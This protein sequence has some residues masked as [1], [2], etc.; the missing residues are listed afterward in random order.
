MLVQPDQIL[1][2]EQNCSPQI[3]AD[4]HRGELFKLK[5][6]VG[7]R[8][9]QNELAMNVVKL[10]NKNEDPSFQSSQIWNSSTMAQQRKLHSRTPL[11]SLQKGLESTLS[12]NIRLEPMLQTH[13]EM[14]HL[15]DRLC[16]GLCLCIRSYFKVSDIRIYRNIFLSE[17]NSQD[18][19]LANKQ[20]V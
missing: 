4:E 12:A 19:Q 10:G 5:D 16:T 2:R 14:F 15:T 1:L 3:Y 18:T 7:T 8:T 13:A 9:N 17:K 20:Q 11:S 6:H